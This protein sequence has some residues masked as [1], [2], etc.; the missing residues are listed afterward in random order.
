MKLEVGIRLDIEGTIYEFDQQK[1]ISGVY[2]F[3]L[4]FHSLF[5]YIKL[6]NI[7]IFVSPVTILVVSSCTSVY[8]IKLCVCVCGLNANII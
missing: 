3:L 5:Q 7:E 2:A 6:P 4:R 8:H 1:L